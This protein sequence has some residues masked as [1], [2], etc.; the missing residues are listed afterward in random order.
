MNVFQNIKKQTFYTA[1]FLCLGVVTASQACD[2][3]GCTTSSGSSSFGD[4]STSNFVGVRYIHQ[5]FES[6]DGIFS[7]SPKSEETFHTYQLWGR[8]PLSKNIY[9]SAIVPFQ[10]LYRHF[11]DRTEHIHGLGDINIMGWY[12]LNFYKKQK[13]DSLVFANRELSG[14]G[15]NFGLGM[16]LP[17]GEFEE[18]LTDRVNPGFQVGTG[19]WDMVATV[20]YSYKKKNLG[21]GAS[22]AYY[23]KTEN[24]NDYKFGNQFSSAAN[25]FYDVN[26]KTTTLRPFLGVSGDVYESIE[27]Y[28]E[29]LADTNGH[30]IYGS[31]GAEVS[32]N[33][34]IL[35]LKYTLPIAQDLFGGDVNS[36][37]QYSLYLNYSL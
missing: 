33:K 11:D 12:Q 22:L 7:N 19:S 4:L 3:C 6:R 31:L 13:R 36:Q 32:K 5:D 30:I 34:F 17:T 16:K 21:V 18:Q 35:G 29:T 15:L 10:D 27:Q 24:E 37:Q 14:H 28:G 26:L 25:V 20:L 23:L 8:V 9:V 2:L 1:L